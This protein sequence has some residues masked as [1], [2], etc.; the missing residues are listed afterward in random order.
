MRRHFSIGASFALAAALCVAQAARADVATFDDIAFPGSYGQFVLNLYDGGLRFQE[1]NLNLFTKGL[2]PLPTGQSSTYL[3]SGSIAHDEN[4][5]ITSYTGTTTADGVTQGADF[6]TGGDFNLWYL[7]IGL[8]FGNVGPDDTV[9]ISGVSAPGCTVDCNPTITLGLDDLP[10]VTSHFQLITLTGFTD[11]TSVTI[12]RPTD[13]G[14]VDA[15]WLAFDDV[16]ST[17][18]VADT[19]NGDNNPRPDAPSPV[20]DAVPEPSAWALM[21]LGFGGVGALLRR[22][23]HADLAAA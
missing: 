1:E 15:G 11:L 19:G 2:S 6:Q 8:A 23:R 9:T 7:K 10:P 3:T 17:P 21:I 20:P 12:G 22:R 13:N 4:L 18:F 16:V 14:V 5:T